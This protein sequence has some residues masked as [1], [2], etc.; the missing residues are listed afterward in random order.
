MPEGRTFLEGVLQK[1]QVNAFERN[2]K[3]REVCIDH[4]GIKCSVCFIS[5]ADVYGPIAAHVIHI[6]HLRPLSEI[7]KEYV[8]DPIADLRPVCPNCHTVIHLRRPPY[9]ISEVQS[10]LS[11]TRFL[12]DKSRN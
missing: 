8:L 7:R 9:S 12:H 11:S 5:L 1:Y 4:Y 6:H 2:Q 10:I 3:A